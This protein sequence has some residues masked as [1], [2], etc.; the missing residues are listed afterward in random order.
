MIYEMQQTMVDWKYE[1]GDVAYICWIGFCAKSRESDL[2][3]SMLLSFWS[4]V[5]CTSTYYL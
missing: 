5:T 2:Y 1:E 4:I 3:L